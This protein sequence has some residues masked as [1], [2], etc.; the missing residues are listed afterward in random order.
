MKRL[1]SL[2]VLGTFAAG[3]SATATDSPS[4][5][6]FKSRVMPVLV[7]VNAHG[8]VTRVSPSSTL[9]PSI[10]RLLRK[11][12]E[13]I[14]SGPAMEHQQPVSS[15]FVMNV[16]LN[17]TPQAG[18]GYYAQF[19]YVSAVPAPAGPQHWVNIDGHQ[20]ALGGNMT[21]VPFDRGPSHM[22]HITYVNNG[23]IDRVAASPAPTSAPSAS[24]SL[25]PT[26]SE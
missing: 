18:G 16:V 22:G 25:A 2:V 7:Q 4:L 13:E 19:A 21:R 9:T 24:S 5:N 17:T 3:C 20:L 10:S 12:I 1:L 15:Q 23:H 26:H 6:H 14:V 8:K 11:N